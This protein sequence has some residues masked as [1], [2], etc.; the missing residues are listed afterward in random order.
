MST[1]WHVH[2]LDCKD[3]NKFSNANHQE[4]LMAALCKHADAIAGLAGLMSESLISNIDLTT[5]YGQVDVDWFAKHRGHRLCPINEYGAL[6]NQCTEYV[7]CACGSRS[8]CRLAHAHEGAHSPTA[9][10][11][12]A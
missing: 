12:H 11:V 2:C 5:S 8:R 1:Y 7:N 6:L 9:D 4:E 3:T 10:G